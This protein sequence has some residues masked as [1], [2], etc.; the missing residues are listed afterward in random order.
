MV[1]GD[2]GD[3]DPEPDLPRVGAAV[4]IRGTGP[5]RE[6]LQK[7]AGK[8]RVGGLETHR[9]AVGQVIADHVNLRFGGRQPR[10][11]RRQGGLQTHT[12]YPV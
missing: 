6:R 4:V 8:Y 9:L 10:Q 2:F 5:E 3:L 11:G 7:L 12:A 1:G